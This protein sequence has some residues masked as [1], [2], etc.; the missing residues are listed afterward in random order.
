M[1]SLFNKFDE[2]HVMKLEKELVSL[3]PHS[4][5]RIEDYFT[6]VKEL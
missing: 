3:D 4:F 1:K 5:E 2:S 6:P